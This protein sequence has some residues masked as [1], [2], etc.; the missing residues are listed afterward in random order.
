VRKAFSQPGSL[1]ADDLN[2]KSSDSESEIPPFVVESVNPRAYDALIPAY[3]TPEAK[4]V[5]ALIVLRWKMR[6]QIVECDL[7]LYKHDP[8]VGK[9]GDPT[10]TVSDILSPLLFRMPTIN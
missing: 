4:G 3:K 10:K 6:G 7:E 5:M 9:L 1:A 8:R 2:I